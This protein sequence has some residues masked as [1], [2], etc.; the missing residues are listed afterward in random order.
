MSSHATTKK[1]I[2]DDGIASTVK[3]EPRLEFPWFNTAFLRVPVLLLL[4][5]SAAVLESI[6]LSSLTSIANADV[7]WHLR[8]GLWMFQ[9]HGLPHNGIYSQLSQTSWIAGSWAY[10]LVLALGYKLLGLRSLPAM[11]M[12]FRASLA[13]LTFVLAGGLRGR[14]WLTVV[15]SA[16]AQYVLGGVPLSDTAC[17]VLFFGSQLCL[18]FEFRRS[19]NPRVLLW[20]APLFLLWANS[21]PQFVYGI[22]LLLLLLAASLIERREHWRY[23]RT[24]LLIGGLAVAASL[25]TP[26][27]YRSYTISLADF[28]SSAN[29][30]FPDYKAMSFHQPQDYLLLLLTMAAFL[31]LGIRRSR[32]LFPILLLIGS[33]ILSFHAQ[34]DTWI[35][36]LVSIAILGSAEVA[37]QQQEKQVRSAV[38]VSVGVSV[39]IL[40]AAFGI[41]VPRGRDALLAKVGTSY[42]VAA[43]NYL[44]QHGASQP[45]FNAYEWGGFLMWYQPE[46]PVA[47]D[48]RHNLYSGD[49][50]TQYAKM[51]NAEIPYTAYP[52]LA[53]A[54]TILL[55]R[56]S[57]MAEALSSLPAFEVAYQD[58]VSVL[59]TSASQEQ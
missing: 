56:T 3:T 24:V 36:A 7:W 19:R 58:D 53:N 32:D 42:P 13:V 22:A 57:I 46:I 45:L 12:C 29:R 15:L 37:P 18:L 27:S 33:A 49:F 43:C 11:M 41:G 9:N 40:I 38:L 51:M 2:S 54:R 52:A 55:P 23:L 17:S 28:T 16:S 1:I 6:R 26:Q 4:L 48:G 21:S 47:I 39:L 8:T 25:V 14:F 59:L 31:S 10:D 20:L 35:A 5:A 34:R 30:Y 50:Y 44:R